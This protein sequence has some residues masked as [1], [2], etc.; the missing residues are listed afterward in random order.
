LKNQRDP[1]SIWVIYVLIALILL[2]AFIT[3]WRYPRTMA[4][5]FLERLPL[6][7]DVLGPR[8]A[9][10]NGFENLK[11]END[12][13]RYKLQIKDYTNYVELREIYEELA[14]DRKVRAIIGP[15]FSSDAKEIADLVEKYKKLTI[16][17]GVTNPEV[18]KSS[19]YFIS[20]GIS[21]DFQIKA[22]ESYV[23]NMGYKKVVIV[24]SSS[25]PV[26]TDYI[27][28]NLEKDLRA[29]GINIQVFT[30]YTE[31]KRAGFL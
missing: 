7:I 29:S 24:K 1:R 15:L 28:S 26:Y 5:G 17:Q 30:Y 31:K 11:N 19:K 21:D 18:L 9:V 6:D 4:I 2:G 12:N 16:L 23:K 3:Y 27:A 10:I 13:I 8:K 14:L 22:I 20:T 25:N